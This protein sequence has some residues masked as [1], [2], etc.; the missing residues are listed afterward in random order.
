MP[1]WWDRA[2]KDQ[3]ERLFRWRNGEWGALSVDVPGVLEFDKRRR[4]LLTGV[5]LQA[6]GEKIREAQLEPVQV[7]WDQLLGLV[8]WRAAGGDVREC[9]WC[10]RL[11]LVSKSRPRRVYCSTNCGSYFRIREAKRRKLKRVKIAMKS[12]PAYAHD[13]KARVARKAHVTP[14][15]ITYA[16]GR[17]EVL[18]K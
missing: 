4:G 5:D 14:N 12:I 16:I 18:N 2:S 3:K 13:W 10:S 1:T 9:R 11:F 8:I 6:F 17:R 7:V 15:F